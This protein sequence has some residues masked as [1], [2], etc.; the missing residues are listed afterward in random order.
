M[1]NNS[2]QDNID[3]RDNVTTR[4]R[5]RVQVNDGANAL[6]DGAGPTRG[7]RVERVMM[8]QDT[9]TQVNAVPN[10][11]AVPYERDVSTTTVQNAP[12]RTPQVVYTP[13]DKVRWGPI[14]AG[15]FTA[16]FVLLVLWLF[17][18]AIGLTVANTSAVASGGLNPNAG[19]YSA[20][21][22]GI[23]G[24]IA[25]LIGGYVAGRAAAVHTRGWAALNGALVFLLALPFILWLATL[26]LTTLIGNAGAI[27]NG[28]GINLSALGGTVHNPTPGQA[29]QAA[30]AVKNAAW[31]A[32][33]GLAVGLVASALGGLLG[34]RRRRASTTANVVTD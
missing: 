6:S 1:A 16:L 18:V 8:P 14:W 13:E 2:N 29:T 31:G 21:W 10:T 15:L 3:N 12:Q 23:S 5:D 20:L 30:S 4:S 27:A 25:F 34:M 22:G 19:Q 11:N 17:G 28:L 26:G 24:I 32:L 33:I 7:E 9:P